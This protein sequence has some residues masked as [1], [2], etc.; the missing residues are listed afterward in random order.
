MLH[1]SR[2]RRA[3]RRGREDKAGQ[4]EQPGFAGGRWSAGQERVQ[5][6]D[7]CPTGR[8]PHWWCSWI[9]QLFEIRH[10]NLRRCIGGRACPTFGAVFGPLIC[11]DRA[12][13]QP[14]QVRTCRGAAGTLQ[15][16]Y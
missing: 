16:Q 10:V 2:D 5:E 1:G 15:S 8:L 7:A 11:F 9:V 3:A 12:S 14:L 13:L 6:R 4:G